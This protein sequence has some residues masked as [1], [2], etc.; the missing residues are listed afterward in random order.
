MT[1]NEISGLGCKKQRQILFAVNYIYSKN[2][3]MEV[4]YLLFT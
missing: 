1:K 4:G 2:Y 3:C